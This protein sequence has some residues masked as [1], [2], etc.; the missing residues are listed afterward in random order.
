MRNRG[1]NPIHTLKARSLKSDKEINAIVT[2]LD[3]LSKE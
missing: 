3:S 1:Q 2:G